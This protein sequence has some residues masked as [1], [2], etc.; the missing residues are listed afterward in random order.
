[1]FTALMHW[2]QANDVLPRISDT[3]RQAL[4]AGNV[5]V[6]GQFFSGKPDFA[7]MLDARYGRL[8]A[9]E[10]AFMDGPVE[11]LLSRADCNEIALTRRVPDHIIEFMAEAGFFG[12]IIPR[13]YGG[14][15]FSTLARSAIMAKVTPHSG[16]LSAYVV[17]PNTL[18][19][20]ELL[21]EYG[22]EA[23]Q[24]HY[25][26]RLARGEY[27]PC[28]G[29]T[30]PTAGSDAA[31]LTAD[32]EAFR[33]ADDEIRLRLNF[34]KRYITLGPVANL[35]SLAC[36][37]RDPD[38]LLGQGEA[39]GITVVLIHG[40]TPGLIQGDRHEPIGE[41][42]PN[43]PLMGEDVVVSADNILGGR[44]QAGGGW[45][46]LMESLAGGR[47][48]SLPATAVGGIRTVAAAT[49]AYSMVRQ[50]FGL[51]IGRMEGVATPIGRLNAL[52]YMTEGARVFGCT[53]VD[54]GIN[55]PV[56]SGVMKAYTTELARQSATDAMD[57]F[58]G[59][60]VM[61]GPNNIIG[62]GYCSAPVAITVEGA[63]IMTRTLMVFGQGAIRCHPHALDVVHAVE[64]DD[65]RA[66]SKGMRGWIGHF[67]A[68]LGR[69]VGHG[70]TRGAFVRV[71]DVD[72]ATKRYYRKLGWAASRFALFTDLA[73][74]F[75]GGR[76]KMRGN[77]TG[78]YADALAW[79]LMGFSTLRRFEA[80]GRPREDRVLVDYALRLSL[81]KVQ[82]A[83]EGIYENFD[84]PLGKL[85]RGVFLPI[86][87]VNRL[88]RLPDDR[89][90]MAAA[91]V[92]QR[93]DAQSARLNA[94][95]F[96]PENPDSGV[97]RLFDAFHRVA[98][99]APIVER[100]KAEQKAGELP[101]GEPDALAQAAREAGVIEADEAERLSAARGARLAAIEV[102]VFSESDFFA[103]AVAPS[104]ASRRDAA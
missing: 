97:G 73:L 21:V 45:R 42:F 19:A 36:R 9:E 58:S 76:L 18:G 96:M 40:G 78:R 16:I 5:W 39:P 65:A 47:M 31:S 22:T 14:K 95:I 3:E 90:A 55:P 62:R 13:A 49:G 80:E 100:I 82:E 77:L 75:V 91:A 52:A 41:A 74:F 70:L 24:D 30:E 15:E 43:G 56:V 2:M 85:L 7:A 64:N 44:D 29:L 79:M 6:D 17:I 59:A 81:A 32:A 92:S 4:E 27:L 1:M 33:D 10:Q 11:E 50:Q 53:A 99:T 38:N 102:D 23:Q 54:D 25:L 63:N 28:F 66:F 37:L 51:P 104:E 26:P 71:P 98:D 89:M 68:N 84:G 93:I 57:V 8:S 94:D 69:T 46:M 35:I 83:F 72:A 88:A 48:V 67:L 86:L 20:A 87:R 61:Q 34:R 60:G 101:A 103:R 12:L